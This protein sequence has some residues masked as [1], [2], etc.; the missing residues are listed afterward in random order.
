MPYLAAVLCFLLSG[1]SVLLNAAQIQVK[2]TDLL[3]QSPNDLWD[4]SMGTVVTRSSGGHYTS[5]L[6]KMFGG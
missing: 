1:A 6:R 2:V 3:Y 4:V 5:D